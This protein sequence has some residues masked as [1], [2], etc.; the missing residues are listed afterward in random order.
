MISGVQILLLEQS[1]IECVSPIANLI[2]CT[3]FNLW[4][5]IS[6]TSIITSSVISHRFRYNFPFVI[7][8]RNRYYVLSIFTMVIAG[9]PCLQATSD[10][11]YRVHLTLELNI[12]INFVL[13]PI[14]FL[15]S[16]FPFLTKLCFSKWS[17]IE[18]K[19][20]DLTTL[21]FCSVPRTPWLLHKSEHGV[22]TT[23]F[24]L[25]CTT[26]MNGGGNSMWTLWVI[27][28]TQKHFQQHQHQTP[29]VVQE[30]VVEESAIS[31]TDAATDYDST[32]PSD[33]TVRR[34]LIVADDSDLVIDII[35]MLRNRLCDFRN[36]RGDAAT[37]AESQIGD[38]WP[39]V[40]SQYIFCY[41]LSYFFTLFFFYLENDVTFL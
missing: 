8:R 31:M 5:C 2:E 4:F 33:R 17:E 23:E 29:L 26:I 35:D 28:G 24:P 25:S 10:R 12:I 13:P 34:N 36:D 6:V 41:Y 16:R 21:R 3:Y 32:C 15:V 19:P 22:P 40:T 18:Q 11:S 37:S 27:S 14:R 39:V 7:C 1:R 38:A 20:S 9:R 30:S